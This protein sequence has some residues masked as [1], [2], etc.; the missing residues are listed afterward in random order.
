MWAGP[1]P[2]DTRRHQTGPGIP[3]TDLSIRIPSCR[4]PS[5]ADQRGGATASSHGVFPVARSLNDSVGELHDK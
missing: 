1:R 4:R 3:I 2:P 5:A